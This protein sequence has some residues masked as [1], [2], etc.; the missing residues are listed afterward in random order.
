MKNFT[1]G[2]VKTLALLLTLTLI[3]CQQEDDLTDLSQAKEEKSLYEIN[4][5]HLSEVP[6]V[7]DFLGNTMNSRLSSKNTVIDGAIF[8]E[9]VLEVIDTL[10]NTNYTFKFTYSD[11]PKQ[12]FYNLVIGKTP[13]GEIKIPYVLKYVCDEAYLD[14][15]ISQ[16]FNFS[17]FNGDVSIHK[18]TDFFEVNSFSRI[19]PCP[20]EL[21]S[22]GEPVSCTTV[23]VSGSDSGGGSNGDD[24]ST[25]SGDDGSNSDGS[26]GGSSGSCTWTVETTGS[27]CIDHEPG[28]ECGG[29]TSGTSTL[30]IKCPK[31]V[32]KFNS[33]TARTEDCPPC[34]TETD[35][36]VG[37]L[38]NMT[39]AQILI[40]K[41][42]VNL[43]Q[44]QKDWLIAHPNESEL[45]DMYITDYYNTVEAKGFAT[46]AV[47]AYEDGGEVDFDNE[48]V[49][50]SSFDSTKLKCVHDKLVNDTSNNFY[51]LMTSAFT[52]DSEILSY[53]VEPLI[54]GDWGITKGHEGNNNSFGFD[55]YQ[56]TMSSNA[57][58]TSNIIKM[59]TLTHELIHAYMFNSLDDMGII[60]YDSDG[61]P[62]FNT[63]Q[64]NEYQPN[65]DINSLILKDRWIALICAY[66]SNNPSNID[67]THT[68]FNTADFIVNTYKSELEN[69][70]L[71]QHDWDSEPLILK[72]FL[73]TEF[74]SSWK[75]KA[76]EYISWM[77]LEKTNEFITWAQANNLELIDGNGN[78]SYPTYNAM[79]TALET[80]GQ[81]NCL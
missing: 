39:A 30:V 48:I 70:I 52:N 21:D 15:F 66:N 23:N 35:G 46:Q 76:S 47:I 55:F 79:K 43:N 56:I 24:T 12:E 77:G 7:I 16:N 81:S 32:S 63:A 14:N 68:L 27:T 78:T 60:Y 6:A 9:N 67:W 50:L 45:I 3:N 51:R 71:N 75:E 8:Q 36:G 22:N 58:N 40:N 49:Y 33:A 41:L 26:Y 17:Y 72:T 34:Q 2:V 64:C 20:P 18:Y 1:R 44:D 65:I 61:T 38:S 31:V 62:L 53:K 10:N 5:L 13:E 28:G 57:E 25:G 4:T 73:Q 54:T 42:G 80:L 74:G 19:E 37:I 29:M 59:V 69:L 11:T